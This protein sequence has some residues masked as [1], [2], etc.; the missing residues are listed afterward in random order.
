MN[1]EPVRA[2]LRHAEHEIT[3]LLSSIHEAAGRALQAGDYETAAASLE[4]AKQ[5]A[6]LQS[7]LGIL[8]AAYDKMYPASDTLPLASTGKT[9]QRI[10]EP[11]PRK[12]RERNAVLPPTTVARVELV[13]NRSG[14]YA[15]GD[16]RAGGIEVLAGSIVARDYDANQMGYEAVEAREKLMKSGEYELE[17][18]G[19]LLRLL[20]NH[21]FGSPTAAGQFVTGQS[22]NGAKE[23]KNVD[24]KERIEPPKR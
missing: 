13:R 16:Y 12:A 6:N 5:I 17:E 9:A 20:S 22:T 7:Q 1:S 4:S 14:V 3:I 2:S 8:S 18:Y 19:N 21:K 15:T 10:A 11:G 23:W 24:T